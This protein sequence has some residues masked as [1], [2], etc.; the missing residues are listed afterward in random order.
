MKM[1]ASSVKIR[2]RLIRILLTPEI[3][4]LIPLLLLIF[5]TGY[6]KP[7][8]LSINNFAVILRY[9]TFMGIICVG[10]ALV[11]MTGEV[12]I[13]LGSN[14]CFCGIVFGTCSM[15]LG[16]PGAVSIIIAILAG[17]FMGVINGFLVAKVGLINFIATLST[18][19]LCQG[20]ATAISNGAVLA[21]LDDSF[22][23][24]GAMRPLKL[25]WPF[26]IFV[27]I[28]IFMEIMVRK[29]K[30]G[31][32]IQAVGGN[33]DAAY[34]S[35]INVVKVKWLVYV[36]AGALAGISGVL[37]S[38]DQASSSPTAGIGLEF[39]AVAACAAGGISMQ[40]GT[41]S[42]LGC[43]IG[44]LLIYV[45][46]NSLQ[47]LG[48]QSNWQMIAMGVILVMSVLFDLTKKKLVAADS[49]N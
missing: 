19:Y 20:L 31:R 32:Q 9:A 13:S 43:G 36:I 48:V 14:L 30:A 28:F 29:S 10:Q 23:K 1:K 46:Q 8:F 6:Q 16:L 5:Y 41:G 15:T 38:I 22:Y 27:A 47:I 45:L 44:I 25:S 24:F 33:M 37:M 18:Q 34:C 3:G 21:P 35:G 7:A 4:I 12:D 11:I 26:F 39:R 49:I 42:I 2:K 17:A 40:G